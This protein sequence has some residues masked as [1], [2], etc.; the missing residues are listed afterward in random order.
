MNTCTNLKDVIIR[1]N[2]V[3]HSSISK[4]NSAEQALL[5][6]TEVLE[7][8]DAF[9]EKHGDIALSCG[10]EWLYQSDR[11]QVDAIEL[12]SKILDSLSEYAD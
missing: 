12:V 10:S 11:G 3:K 2:A 6:A 8:V 1:L 7:L 4:Y 5:T 9:V